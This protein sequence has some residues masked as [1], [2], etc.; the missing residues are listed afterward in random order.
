MPDES[1][2][3]IDMTLFLEKTL[4]MGSLTQWHAKSMTGRDLSLML[5]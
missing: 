1:I 5:P 4:N 3:T 2:I